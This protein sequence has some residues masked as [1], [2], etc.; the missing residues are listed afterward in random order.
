M[1][2]DTSVAQ[3]MLLTIFHCRIK[4]MLHNDCYQE[5]FW[6]GTDRFGRDILSRLIIGVSVSLAVGLITVIISL[7]IG[8][9]LGALAGYFRGWIDNLMWLINVIWSIPTLLLV[10]GITLALG[11]GFWQI[12]IAVGLTMWVSVARLDPWTGISIAR[13]GVHPGGEGTGTENGRIIS[14]H[15]FQMSWAL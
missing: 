3:I 6:L 14:K 1:D 9:F 2:E 10:F 4:E 11:K 8:I 15:I 7:T 5:N 13:T 12:F